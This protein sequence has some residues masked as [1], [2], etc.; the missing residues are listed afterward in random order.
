MYLYIYGLHAECFLS[1]STMHSYLLHLCL[2]VVVLLAVHPNVAVFP[3]LHKVLRLSVPLVVPLD[4]LHNLSI[5][6]F[7]VLLLNQG[8]S[9]Y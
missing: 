9:R 1:A 6:S 8:C 3:D 2:Y 4:D 5:N 7:S